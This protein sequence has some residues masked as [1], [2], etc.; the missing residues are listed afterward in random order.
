[1]GV[2]EGDGAA[3]CDGPAECELTA[4]ADAEETGVDDGAALAAVLGAGVSVGA[5]V[6]AASMPNNSCPPASNTK[7]TDWRLPGAVVAVD[8]PASTATEVD[9]AVTAFDRIRWTSV[10]GVELQPAAM[11]ATDSNPA[12]RVAID[13]RRNTR[14]LQAI[15]RSWTAPS[16]QRRGAT[17]ARQPS[18]V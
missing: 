7:W 14:L 17:P 15:W 18:A 13:F 1:V 6:G 3:D 11:A 12:A 8:V 4:D 9:I 10:S 16:G 2:A 5:A